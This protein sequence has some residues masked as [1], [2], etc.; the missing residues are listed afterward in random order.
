MFS[1]SYHFIPA[2]KPKLF[3]RTQIMGAD[4]YI[5]DLEDAVPNSEKDVALKHLKKWLEQQND[6]SRF[7]VRLNGSRE[8]L[9]RD[10]RALIKAFPTLGVV[11]PKIDSVEHLDHEFESYDLGVDSPVVALIESA[12]GL[13]N[14]DGLMSGNRLIGVALGLED[15]FSGS[16]HQ[17]SELS[18]LAAHIRVEIAL[19]AMKYGIEAIDTISTDLNGGAKLQSE[20]EAAKS[21]GMT[22]KLSIHPLQ[23]PSINTIFSPARTLIEKAHRYQELFSEDKASTGY[24]SDDGEI[25]SPPKLKKLNR[26]HQY[27]THYGI[28]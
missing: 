28:K 21:A 22:G 14:L 6:F 25:L 4:R 16:I 27:A 24:I 5:F 18:V 8:L 20:I 7:Y 23:I 9:L 15:F 10:E 3:D 11:L 13:S 2:N 1:R 17:T 19:Q 12:Q 26:I